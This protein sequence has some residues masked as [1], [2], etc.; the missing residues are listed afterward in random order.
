MAPWLKR[1]LQAG[2][3][4]FFQQWRRDLINRSKAKGI[5]VYLKALQ[6]A[7]RSLI[8]VAAVIVTLQ[9]LLVGL[10]MALGAAVYLLPWSL[11]AK[12]YLVLGVGAALFL[13]PLGF[14]FYALSERVWYKASGAE[15]MVE[16]FLAENR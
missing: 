12:A 4:F 6:G 15:E 14:L 10:F 7:R 2:L 8:F 16:K 1:F 3:L 11:E 5:A 9:L 13:L